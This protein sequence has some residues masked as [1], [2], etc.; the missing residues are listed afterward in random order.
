[1]DREWSRLMGEK[2]ELLH[3][4]FI[5]V[6]SKLVVFVCFCFCFFVFFSIINTYHIVWL[7]GKSVENVKTISKKLREQ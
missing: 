2:F 7:L 5:L 6:L 4:K 3:V 1:M